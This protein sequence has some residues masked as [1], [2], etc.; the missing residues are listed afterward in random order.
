M[1]TSP[2]IRTPDQRLR[3]FVSSTLR[4]LADE[5][6][7]VREA[8][9]QLHLSPVMFELG[10]RP[11]PAINLYRAYL[12]QSH[13]F[14]GIYWQSY[15]Y[16]APGMPYSGLEDEYLLASDK[17][18]LIYI[19]T[20]A[21]QR[22]P[23]LTSLLARIR[24]D[25][26]VSYKSFSSADELRRLVADDLALILTERFEASQ[27]AG[28]GSVGQ[29]ETLQVS[30]P[31]PLT[32]FIGRE[33]EIS[34]ILELLGQ[35][36]VRLITLTG[37]GGTGKTRLSLQVASIL[38]GHY[39][40][41]VLFVPLAEA[42]NSDM[43]VSKIA[44]HLGVREG[45]SQS[46]LDSLKSY[47]Q[48][49]HTLLVLD[50][51]EQVLEA[52]PMLAGMLE[53]APHIQALVTSRTLLHVRGEHEFKVPTL[54]IPEPNTDRDLAQLADCESIRLFIDRARMTNPRLLLDAQSMPAIA[55]ICRR[56]D[57]LPLALELAAARLKMLSP[58]KLLGMLSS[59]LSLLTGGSR[60]LPERQQ[61]L[62]NTLD[63]SIQLLDPP[64]QSLF[65]RLGVF[66]GGF[67]LEAAQEVC[68]ASVSEAGDVFQGLEALLNNSLLQ[69]DE[70][71]E[72]E[73]R[74]R[75]LET[76]RD[77]ALERLADR[78]ELETFQARH[79]QYFIN[80]MNVVNPLLATRQAEQGL[81]WVDLERDNLR[82]ALECC[83]SNASLLEMAPWLL[84]AHNW[85]WY[86]RGFLS[87]GRAWANRLLRSPGT[88]K[89]P[90]SRCFALWSSGAMAMWQG[91]LN[92]ALALLN[93]S[94]S[95]SKSSEYPMAIAITLLFLGT[96]QVNRGEDELALESL[97]ESLDLFEQLSMPWYQAITLVHMANASLGMGDHARALQY[98]EQA[99][100]V[101]QDI[102][103]NW[104]NSFILNNYGELA[105]TEGDYQ[106][107]GQYYQE[108]ESLLRAMGDKGDLARLVHNLGCT[109]RHLGETSKAE[110]LIKESL[111]MFTRLGNQRGIAECL[112]SLA[113]VWLDAGQ[114][115][116]A[117]KLLGAAQ[118]LLKATGAAWWPA[119]RGEVEHYLERLHR[120]VEPAQ[121]ETA[122]N[123]GTRL[124]LKMALAYA[125][126]GQ[127]D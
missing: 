100:P 44:E 27:S 6:L 38:Q 116:A 121:F 93:E 5:R 71:D 99:L 110:T 21:T 19:K 95:I 123:A 88:Q 115:L 37:P 76:I 98:L 63:W 61:T 20:P 30:L 62:R 111:E 40:N 64:G 86:R 67:S 114:V 120:E 43:V 72:G 7:A 35:P 49:K 32:S 113:G 59:R 66:V 46:L 68:Q 104:L 85:P 94:V 51:F 57:G 29:P 39:K 80:K 97:K 91:D 83:L 126:D 2:F 127:M 11:H 74:F 13:L 84:I 117:V 75:M 36:Q 45:G 124:D 105:R 41:G 17:P 106:R 78:A 56:L 122:W 28:V 15:G 73:P 26:Q 65:A 101:S 108:S 25:D 1:R 125:Q 109:A 89:D 96:T 92:E 81:A 24:N 33:A 118:T 112:A 102:G 10:A 48:D 77:Y 82:A 54:Q 90:L 103:E 4:E 119:D 53:S 12:E 79:A 18:K 87:E 16:V 107:A 8:I 3:V 23:G 58:D 22:E 42:N 9:T 69:L 34:T 50:N 52:S 31:S 70:A 47:L 14:I 60:D 55:E